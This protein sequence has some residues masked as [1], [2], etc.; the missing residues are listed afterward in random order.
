MN[1]YIR[2][3]L[4]Q[5]WNTG[6]GDDYTTFVEDLEDLY[7]LEY[8]YHTLKSHAFRGV[9]KR[10]EN[11]INGLESQLQELIEKIKKVLISL[12]S[13]WLQ[14]HALDDPDEWASRRF[15]DP[16]GLS[17]EELIEAGAV[18]RRKLYIY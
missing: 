15:L 6:R 12:F 11:M 7:E 16:S 9:E 4:A 8:K 18:L 5:I 3:K 17:I 10:R 2:I 13:S 14:N 1:W